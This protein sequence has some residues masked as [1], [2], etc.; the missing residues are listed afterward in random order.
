MSKLKMMYC[1]LL[2]YISKLSIRQSGL[3][4]YHQC[5]V[6]LYLLQNDEIERELF[7]FDRFYELYHKICPRT[8]VE[9]LFSEM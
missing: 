4:D 3:S 7:T 6:C 2:V 1:Y 8:D 9:Q 5:A